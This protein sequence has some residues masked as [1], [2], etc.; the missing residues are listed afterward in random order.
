M[1]VPSREVS[2]VDLAGLFRALADPNRLAIFELVRERGS[3][4]HTV[5]EAENSIS[6]IAREFDLSLSTV[7]HHL[8]ELRNAGLIHCEKH[9]QTVYCTPVPGALEAIASFLGEAKE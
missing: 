9:G 8:K 3:G 6:K 2:A 4:V 7:S 1:Q 5:E